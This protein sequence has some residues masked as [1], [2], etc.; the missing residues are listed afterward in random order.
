MLHLKNLLSNWFI[1]DL[2]SGG[3]LLNLSFFLNIY[4]LAKQK[5][6]QIVNLSLV[7][8]AVNVELVFVMIVSV[9]NKDDSVTPVQHQTA[10]TNR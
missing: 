3:P 6:L 4:S 1:Q 5:S 7:V 8:L 10:K 9:L 2:F